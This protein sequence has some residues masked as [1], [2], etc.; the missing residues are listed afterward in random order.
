MLM[1][2]IIPDKIFDLNIYEKIGQRKGM[3]LTKVSFLGMADI[4]NERIGDL[5]ISW[6]SVAPLVVR[7]Q[8][9]ENEL[10]GKSIKEI[11]EMGES[12]IKRYEP[13][14]TPID[15]ARS[16]A[17]YRK[18]TSLNLLRKFIKIL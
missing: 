14:I 8:N 15:D 4:S 18:I 17:L 1:K 10:V 11:K 13:L 6:G 12:L 5:R 2:I 16:S 7:D 3:S 9:T